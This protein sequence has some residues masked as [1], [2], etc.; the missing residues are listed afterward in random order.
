MWQLRLSTSDDAVL[1]AGEVIIGNIDDDGYLRAGIERWP[2]CRR[3]VQ[4]HGICADAYPELRSIGIGARDLKECLLIQIRYLD[5]EGSLVEKIVQNHLPDLEKRKYQHIARVLNVTQQ[6][7]MEASTF[8][9]H[10]L[11]PKPGRPYTSAIRST[12]SPTS[13][14]SRWRT[15]T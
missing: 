14:S 2:G 5:L 13:M 15:A 3:L 7:V 12:W 10:E 4:G 1:A 9:I 11:E 6:D 8:I